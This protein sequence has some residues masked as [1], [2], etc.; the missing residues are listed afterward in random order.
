MKTKSQGKGTVVTIPVDF[1]YIINFV[2]GKFGLNTKSQAISKIVELYAKSEEGGKI[3]K[4]VD[5]DLADMEFR[6]EE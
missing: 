4:L 3:K 1:D 2:R 5:A 6:G